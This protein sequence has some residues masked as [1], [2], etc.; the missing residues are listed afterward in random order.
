MNQFK[1]ILE[2]LKN[3]SVWL[4]LF[5]LAQRGT[6]EEQLVFRESSHSTSYWVSRRGFG[7]IN[8]GIGD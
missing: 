2:Q 8:P 7:S 4:S 3:G 1:N 6:R 5:H